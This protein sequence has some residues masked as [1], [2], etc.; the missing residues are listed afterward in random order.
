MSDVHDLDGLA[1]EHFG[2]ALR[3][4]SP[5]LRL[6]SFLATPAAVQETAWERKA[7]EAAADTEHLRDP[8]SDLDRPPR[9]RTAQR[10]PSRAR[11]STSRLPG[12]RFEDDPLVAIDA[13]TYLEVLAGAE[14]SNGDMAR[15]CFHEDRS[16]SLKAYGA[17]FHC[18]GCGR[19]GSIYDAASELWGV[20]T[21]G[22]DFLEL[23]QRLAQEL[24]GVV[25]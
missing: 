22:A 24:L 7:R 2:H 16:P 3:G 4:V 14:F 13:V 17:Q 8:L 15:C 23:R 19:H 10:P 6:E 21:R 5:E 9:R 20:G 18:F 25:A 12:R 11:A 1:L